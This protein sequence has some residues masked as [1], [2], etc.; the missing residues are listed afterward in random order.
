[1]LLALI[2][3][4]LNVILMNVFLLNVVAPLEH[5]IHLNA[6]QPLVR[7]TKLFSLQLLLWKNKLEC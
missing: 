2:A 3:I 4:F 5:L 7:A 1:M 6:Q